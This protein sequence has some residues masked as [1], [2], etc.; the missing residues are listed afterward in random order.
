MIAYGLLFW[1]LA[2]AGLLLLVQSLSSRLGRAV[3]DD[4]GDLTLFSW[5]AGLVA[6]AGIVRAASAFWAPAELLGSASGLVG[7]GLAAYAGWRA[8]GWLVAELRR[9]SAKGK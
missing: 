5:A 6:L 7:A 1:H 4:I 9:G 3:R 2:M 8:W